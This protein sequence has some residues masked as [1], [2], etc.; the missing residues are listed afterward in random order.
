M[1]TTITT[2]IGFSSLNFSGKTPLVF[3]H[4]FGADLNSWRFNVSLLAKSREV[5]SLDLPGHGDSWEDSMAGEGFGPG[6]E[7]LAEDISQFLMLAGLD[8]VHLMGKFNASR[9][10]CFSNRIAINYN[11]IFQIT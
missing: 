10:I 3:L 9:S 5:W 2:V 4:G 6:V 1:V 7:E 8:R 11:V